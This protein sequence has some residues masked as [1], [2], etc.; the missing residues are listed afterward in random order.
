MK[1]VIQN[2]MLM[3]KYV[4]RFCPSHIFITILN[5]ILASIISVF[6][7]LFQRHVVNTITKSTNFKVVSLSVLGITIVNITYSFIN[8]WLQQRIIPRNT[9]ILRQ[10]MQMEIFR[11]A[12]EVD[13]ECYEDSEYFNKFT[14]ATQQAGSRAVAVLSTFSSLIGSLS[15]IG[16]LVTLISCLDPIILMF[17]ITNVAIYFYCSTKTIKIQHKYYEEKIPLEREIGYAQRVFYQREYAKDIRLFDK[18]SSL[19]KSIFNTSS[20][21]LISLIGTYGKKLSKYLGSH[22]ILGSGV[23]SAIMLYLSYRVLDK[24]LSIADFIALWSSSQQ[25]S[26]QI[27]QLLDIFPKLYENSIYIDNFIGLINYT[28]QISENHNSIDATNVQSIEFKDVTFIYPNTDKIV[29]KNIN[30]KISSGEKVAFVGR[31]GAG[32]SSLVKLITRLYD[33]TEGRILLND[34][35]YQNYTVS[36]LRNNIGI[37]FQDYQTYAMTIAENVLMRPMINKAEDEKLVNN[38]LKFVGLYDKVNSISMGM[39]TVLTRE[40]KNTGAIFSGGEL[41]KLAIARIYVKNC[42]IIILDEPSSALDPI[43]ENEILN[44]VLDLASNKTVILISHRLANVKNVDRIFFIEDGLLVESGSHDEL[45]NMNGKYA[46]MYKI[47]VDQYDILM[48]K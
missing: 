46:E 8:I 30:I 16:A 14:L 47:Q 26:H 27:S 5:A 11:K 9:Q 32:K 17:V 22:S 34:T 42:S 38:A 7:I 31:N 6:N 2:N 44:S 24:G 23:N 3:L 45:M 48:N 13:Y 40:F 15:G 18:L 29:L 37:V 35:L 1:K 41:Q 33:P 19:I 43:A 12:M 25:L 39:Y 10:K 20:N 21:N 4:A 36:S 28:S